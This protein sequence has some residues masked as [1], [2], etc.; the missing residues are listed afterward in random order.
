MGLR[1]WALACLA[2]LISLIGLGLTAAGAYWVWRSWRVLCTGLSW[3][4]CLDLQGLVLG[5]TLGPLG[6]GLGCLLLGEII[7]LGLR[8]E[9]RLA[10]LQAACARP[11]P[12][13]RGG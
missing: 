10:H 12:D 11:E 13:R 8:I 1:H 4:A 7:A 3:A 5:L 6:I 9:R 2:T